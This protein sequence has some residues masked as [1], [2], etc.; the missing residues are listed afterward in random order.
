MQHTLI[1]GASPVYGTGLVHAL[2]FYFPGRDCKLA[3]FGTVPDADCELVIVVIGK[4]PTELVKSAL[5]SLFAPVL[6]V[7]NYLSLKAAK[8]LL[9]AGAKGYLLSTTP[10][11]TFEPAVSKVLSGDCF[12]D[13]ILRE[14][15]LNGQLGSSSRRRQV[16]TLTKREQEVL[17][18][19]V[20]GLTTG[21]IA[22]KLFIGRC[23]A[24]THRC[25]ILQK[26]GVRNTAGIVREAI[27][28]E[29]CEV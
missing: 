7:G 15:W 29:L 9:A 5:R 24:E 20:D 17:R 18:L 25:H 23:T 13:P 12:L 21:E 14:E 27:R 19:I 28:R 11:E 16:S 2:K 26:L 10:L 6:L 4:R 8:V 22:E 3:S 1:L